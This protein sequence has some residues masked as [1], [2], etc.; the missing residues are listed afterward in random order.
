MAIVCPQCGKDD[1]IQNVSAVYSGGTASG[2]YSGPSGGIAT[3]L[4]SGKPAL[5]GGYTTL[6]GTSGVSGL[7]L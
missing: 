1:M 3:P 4:G 2:S 6:H 5:V 7:F